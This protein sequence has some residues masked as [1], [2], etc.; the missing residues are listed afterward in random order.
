MQGSCFGYL[1]GRLDI[2]QVII[3]ALRDQ[4]LSLSLQ[5]E[6]CRNVFA[7]PM[8]TSPSW[9][10]SQKSKNSSSK[11]V[12]VRISCSYSQLRYLVKIIFSTIGSCCWVSRSRK[13]AGNGR[14]AE[15]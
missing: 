3:E 13:S 14:G 4:Q 15:M 7:A 1:Q 8:M 12:H 9:S 2:G 6:I 5:N 11:S 10:I